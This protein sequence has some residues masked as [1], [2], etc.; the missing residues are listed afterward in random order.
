MPS[1]TYYWWVAT[2]CGNN[3][4]SSWAYGGSF[5][6]PSA[7][8]SCWQSISAGYTHSLG[9]KSNGTLWAWG[10]NSNG[11]LGDGTTT[12]R[13][14]PTQVGTSNNWL[15]V[16]GGAQFSVGIKTD[17]TL[18]AWG[19]NQFGQLGDGT[20]INRVIPTQIGTANTW[21]DI[22]A[23]GGFT[24][25]TKE[26]NF[27]VWAWGNNEYGQLGDGTTIN[28]NVPTA[29]VQLPSGYEYKI[30]AGSNFSLALIRNQNQQ[31]TLMTWGNNSFGQLGDGTT[32]NRTTPTLIDIG[33]SEWTDIAAGYSHSAA[34]RSNALLYTWGQNNEGQLGDGTNINRL[35]S[36]TLIDG[37][38]S[39][40]AGWYYTVGTSYFGNMWSCGQNVFGQLG[41]GTNI[42]SN[43]ISFSN[44]TNHEFISQVHSILYLSVM[45]DL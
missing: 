3:T 40:D 28:R 21:I 45:M 15:K 26:D 4:Q 25:A 11:Q 30:A 5:T 39:V 34:I 17:G 36:T 7:A 8:I 9:I 6:T 20:N 23:G 44:S 38:Q 18:W 2:N 43:Q 27:W 16:S 12:N 31:G 42:N 29:V 13:N 24:L 19:S 1:T 10:D 32:T 35:T 22:D 33:H 14:V 41:N 37:I